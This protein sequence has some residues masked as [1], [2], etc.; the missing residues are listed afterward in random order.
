M[1]M[2]EWALHLSIGIPLGLLYGN[3]SEWFVHRF[4]LHGLGKRKGSLWSFHWFEHHKESRLPP[5]RDASYLTPLFSGEGEGVG[6]DREAVALATSCVLHLPIAF[7]VPGFYLGAFASTVMYYFM[8]RKSHLDFAWARKYM[9][10][11]VDHH[12]GPNQDA[13]WCVTFPWSDWIMGTREHYIGT[14]RERL[15]LEK[16]AEREAR[17]AAKVEAARKV[18][19]PAV[20]PATSEAAEPVEPEPALT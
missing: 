3:A 8:H 16:R 15:D 20:E 18:P 5:M 12:L 6:H 10:W 9:P 7:W 17:S 14:E 11:H 2:T 19:A 1:T 4:F 13:N